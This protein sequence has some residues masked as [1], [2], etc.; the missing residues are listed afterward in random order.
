MG[1]GLHYGP[2]VV[3]VMGQARGSGA[4]GSLTAVGDT[5]NTASRLEGLSKLYDCELVLSEDVLA[6]AGLALPGMERRQ[7]ELRGHSRPVTVLAIK[8]ARELPLE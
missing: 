6:A 7:V 2:A 1:I 5:V 3:G 8:A 4:R